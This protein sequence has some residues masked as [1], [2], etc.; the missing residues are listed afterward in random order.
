MNTILILFAL[1]LPDWNTGIVQC[2]IPKAYM[3][4]LITNYEKKEALICLSAGVAVDLVTND[5]ISIIAA[6]LHEIG[7]IKTSDKPYSKPS[8]KREYDAQMWAIN[9][10]ISI[11]RKDIEQHLRHTFS[12]WL[13]LPPTPFNNLYINASKMYFESLKRTK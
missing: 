8:A 4:V 6:T 11:N 7:H 1:L 9:Y 12:R 10:A 13:T 5:T 3:G 2:P